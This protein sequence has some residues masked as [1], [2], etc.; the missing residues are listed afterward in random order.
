[1]EKSKNKPRSFNLEFNRF[2]FS[3]KLLIAGFFML[4]MFRQKSHIFVHTVNTL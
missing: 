1:M 4:L 2:W 3:D